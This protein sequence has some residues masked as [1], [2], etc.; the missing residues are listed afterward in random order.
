MGVIFNI[1]KFCTSDGPG[2]RTTVFLKGCPL[3]CVWCHN[4]ESQSIKTDISYNAERCLNCGKCVARCPNHCHGIECGVHRYVRSDCKACQACVH[5]TCPAMEAYGYEITPEAIIADVMKDA[6]FYQNSG[7]GLTLSGGEP[8]A[9]PEF[10]L[11]ILKLAKEQGLHI[12]METC[13][14]AKTEVLAEVAQ[15]V[16][17][18]LFDYKETDSQKHKTFTGVDNAL[19]L[20]N[21]RFLNSIGKPIIL[22]CPIIPTYNDTEEHFDGIAQIANDLKSIQRVELEP[23]H[24]FGLMKY[25]RLGRRV[26]KMKDVEAPS[27]E[28]MADIVAFLCEKTKTEVKLA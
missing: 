14:F 10:C 25:K 11:S 22:R 19:I 9:Q 26:G 5:P 18:F 6:A 4:P 13:G 12:C 3:K 24:D 27:K 20:Q 2:I 8:L 28:R 23:Y 15:Y 17:L 1:Q 21:L 7:G 16:D